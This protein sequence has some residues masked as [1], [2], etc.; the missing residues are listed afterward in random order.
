[1]RTLKSGDVLQ[2]LLLVNVGL[3]LLVRITFAISSLFN[4]PLFSFTEVS[5]W[6]AIPSNPSQLLLR[7]WSLFTYM[8]FHWEF[9]HLLFNMLWLYWMGA[10][11]LEYLGAKK[12]FGLYI[13][14]GLF[15]ALAYVVA[16][17]TFPIFAQSVN[18]SFALGASASVLAITV[19][20]ATLLPD[21]PISLILIGN[22]ALKWIAAISV[23]LDVINISGENAGGH[24]AHLG[25][26]LFGFIYIKSLQ[27]G[28][29]LT[30]WLEVL[31]DRLSWK[32]GKMTVAYK[33]KKSDEDFALHKKATQEQMDDILDKISKSG[34]GSL[35]QSEKDFL[36]RISKEDQ[37]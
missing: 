13:M 26:A 8:F 4:Y 20:A 25:G 19:A 15:G 37:K 14:G 27:R 33:R 10:I 29:N 32:R 16:F 9:L 34:Y 18:F 28:T 23:L 36:F 17:N 5:A 24:I 30:K 11:I 12:L 6:L 22:V 21:Y 35:S 1:M 31:S 2:R 3:F 7:P